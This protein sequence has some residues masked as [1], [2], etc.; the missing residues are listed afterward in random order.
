MLYDLIFK[1]RVEI[2]FPRA[3]G[4]RGVPADTFPQGGITIKDEIVALAA[5]RLPETGSVGHHLVMVDIFIGPTTEP[6]LGLRQVALDVRQR[7]RM[8]HA[9]FH[10]AHYRTHQHR[11]VLLVPVLQLQTQQADKRSIG[12]SPDCIS[13]H[14]RFIHTYS[15]QVIPKSMHAS[16]HHV[17]IMI[18]HRDMVV[19]AHRKGDL[20]IEVFRHV[21]RSK[22]LVIIQALGRI[23]KT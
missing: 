11:V 16:R 13:R 15:G 8:V 19:I 21:L 20:K 5:Y 10:L 17:I 4:L 6:A 1:F 22:H 3:G 23:P 14:R 7:G 9:D 12:Q 18:G 2:Q